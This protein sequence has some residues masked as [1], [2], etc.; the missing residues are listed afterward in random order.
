MAQC[1]A[2]QSW[3]KEQRI[4]QALFV[5]QWFK[6]YNLMSTGENTVK[7]TDVTRVGRVV[8][9]GKGNGSISR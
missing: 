6:Q 4:F 1:G 7:R 3:V 2:G 9:G 5:A 8:P